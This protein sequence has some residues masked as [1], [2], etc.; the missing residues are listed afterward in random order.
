MRRM[1][2]GMGPTLF[3]AFSLAALPVLV[4]AGLLVERQARGALEAELARRAEAVAV[5]VSTAIPWDTWS[6]LFS[7]GPGEEESRTAQYMRSRLAGVAE[8]VGADRIAV[9]TTGGELVL[10][11]SLRLRIGTPAPRMAMLER[12]LERARGGLTASTPIFRTEAG[13]PMKIGLSPITTSAESAAPPGGVLLVGV[14]SHSLGAIA[15]M[16]R[17]L[18][19]AGLVGWGL[20]L[21][22]AFGLARQLTARISRLIQAARSIGRGDLDTSV[23][24]LGGGELGYLAETLERMR[25]AVRVRERQ[26]RAMV[27]GVAHEIRNPLGGVTLY[28]EMLARDESL[29]PEQKRKAGRILQETLR[30]DRVVSDFLEYARPERPRIEVVALSPV[31][32][33]VAHSAAAGLQWAG[34]CEIVPATAEVA[35]DPDHLRQVLLNL[36][37]NAMEAAG[38]AGRVILRAERGVQGVTVSVEDS[39]PGVEPE[40]RELIFEPF[41]TGKSDG[42]GLGLAIA[43]RLCDLGEL[44]L[45]LGQSDLGGARFLLSFREDPRDRLGV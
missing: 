25:A 7:L 28:A 23:P 18:L 1:T 36:L 3:L 8:R 10:D 41:F 40:A 33:E 19:G 2:K 44:G 29:S 39:G 5:A 16:R 42:A 4:I 43:K 31:L 21:A 12:E 45:E 24:A 9:W 26:L 6:L 38:Q 17:T 20:A 34:V 11:T 22:V 30:L 15:K 35:C 14:P 37:R 32:E 27:G 13:L